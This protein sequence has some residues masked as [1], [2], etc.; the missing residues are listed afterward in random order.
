MSINEVVRVW[1]DE[2]SREQYAPEQLAAMP[3]HPAG[4]IDAEVDQLIGVFDPDNR[5]ESAITTFSRRPC[6]F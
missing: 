6:C 5:I 3:D 1:T 4:S 2:D